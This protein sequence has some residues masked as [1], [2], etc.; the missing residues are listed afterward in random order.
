MKTFIDQGKVAVKK[1]FNLSKRL[2]KTKKKI[3]HNNQGGTIKI[4]QL[5]TFELF[6]ADS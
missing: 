4:A 6:Y 2:V 3:M 5:E 1:H